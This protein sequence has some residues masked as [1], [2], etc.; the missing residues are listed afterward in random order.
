MD[1]TA[2]YAGIEAGGTKFVLAVGSPEDGIIAR[3]RIDTRDP[4]STLA[5]AGDWLERHGPFAA[6]GIGSFGPVE[7]DPAARHYGHITSTPKPGWQ[8]C[9]IVGTFASRFSCPIGFDTDVGAA[10]IAEYAARARTSGGTLAYVT[11]G[12]G[13]GGGLIVDGKPVHGIAHPEMGHYFPR[14]A[15]G[16]DFAGSCPYHR[17]CLEGL[18]SG[19]AILAR[20]GCRLS[21]LEKGHPGHA[22]IADYLG[23][24][25]MMI[26]AA[27]AA[28][29]VV[30]GGGVVQT[31]GLLENVNRRTIELAAGYLPGGARHTIE[32]P[33]LGNDAGIVGALHL[34]R[35]ADTHV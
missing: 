4:F 25:C 17:D 26:F 32:H 27:T 2:R 1:E 3:H 15:Q 5:E 28:K 12:T 11:V 18:V 19:P 31:P 20:W 9:D 10:A 29:T 14:R 16:D 23:Q 21:D 7:L 13:V 6:L 30:L 22:I 35:V 34:A 33:R 8:N 24:L